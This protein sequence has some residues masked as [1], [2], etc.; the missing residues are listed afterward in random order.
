MGA[1][2]VHR[3]YQDLRCDAITVGRVQ[4]IVDET[5]IEPTDDEL[6]RGHVSALWCSD[7]D[8]AEDAV[9]DKW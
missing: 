6:M 8:S 9:Y 4:V 2:T 5:P 3:N 7:W 1:T